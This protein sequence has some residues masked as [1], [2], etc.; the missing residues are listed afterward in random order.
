MPRAASSTTKTGTTKRGSKAKN[1]QVVAVVSSDGGIEGSFVPE[2]KRPLIAH[3]PF[4]SSDVQFEG[5][6][7]PVYNP[8]PPPAP[9]PYDAFNA[10][11]FTS[12]A[13]FLQV[14]NEKDDKDVEFPAP[15][16]ESDFGGK[17]QLVAHTVEA[18][19]DEKALTAFKTID[20]MI[21]FKHAN[22]QRC[23]PESTSAACFWCSGTFEGR[24]V[25]LPTQEEG[26][27]YS[28]YGNFC[29]LACA[30]SHLLNEQIDPQV[31][32]ER[33]SL[34]HRMYKQVSPI[35]PAPPRECLQ[36]FGGKLTHQVYRSVI[37]GK[38]IRIDV[39]LPPVISILSTLDTKPIDFYETSFRNTTTNMSEPSVTV[40][41]TS[42][43]LKRSKPLK[44][45]ESTL[46]AVMNLQIKTRG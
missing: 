8:N 6:D 25:V 32:W 22:E 30:L 26:G 35:Q 44:D 5:G 41:D 43:R 38:Q 31:R 13:E 16:S 45:K 9:E 21:D 7:A 14:G 46:D 27:V 4:R 2:P 42:L 34:L 1:V 15:I 20:V 40:Q 11:V 24:P 33:Q 23:L 28:V 39:H 10:N 17:Q 19:Q 3:L 12:G 29:T 36:F 18:K 37:T